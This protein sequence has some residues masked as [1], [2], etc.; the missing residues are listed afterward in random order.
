[1]NRT[2]I[3]AVALALL[4]CPTTEPTTKETDTE[5]PVTHDSGTPVPVEL[6]GN[7]A[8]VIV[9]QFAPSVFTTVYGFE[10][11]TGGNVTLGVF[12]D[13]DGGVANVGGCVYLGDV[14]V[15]AYPAEGSSAPGI[16]DFAWYLAATS[17]D[18]GTSMEV[19][20]A[21][22]SRNVSNGTFLYVGYPTTFGTG[23]GGV[24]YDGDLAAYAGTAD[25]TYP[26][27]LVATAPDGAQRLMVD[28][29]VGT[30]VHF[31]WT[32]GTVGDILLEG[33]GIVH[34]LADSGTADVDI[35]DLGFV[36]PLDNGVVQL[37]R[38]TWSEVDANGNTLKAQARS[39]Q[40]YN[41]TYTDFAGRSELTVGGNVA[42]DCAGA[43]LLS[44]LAP[45]LYWGNS[46][47][48]V[49]D[50]DLGENNPFHGFPS[51]G[52][53][54]VAP[55]ALLAGQ[56]LTVTYQQVADGSMTLLTDSCATGDALAAA[57]ATLNVDAEEMT[58]TATAD[59]TVYLVLDAYYVFGDFMAVDIAVTG[60]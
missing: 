53:D 22:L 27:T 37:S 59:G 49:D 40:A 18:A 3:V 54:V 26:D 4:G 55:V 24:A 32:P 7:D 44:A 2:A 41:V 33:P 23:A 36:G 57:D 52:A 58:Y 15:L 34:H 56:T 16:T 60:P 29:A 43:K 28:Q 42:E 30:N 17:I 46:A 6:T 13:D 48:S 51:L 21:V 25:F 19:G 47:G 45:G 11:G 14:C 1:M 35:A 9:A 31:E 12:F 39:Y 5:T 20:G 50:I 8:S 10:A 38:A